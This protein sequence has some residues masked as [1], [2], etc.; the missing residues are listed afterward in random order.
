MTPD[1]PLASL[2]VTMRRT[3]LSMMVS[4]MGWLRKSAAETR[5]GQALD[6]EAG[7]REQAAG[8]GLFLR[9]A[10]HRAAHRGAIKD[11]EIGAAEHYAGQV[12]H[13]KLDHAVDPPVR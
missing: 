10:F 11:V 9:H 4:G 3:G 7:D 5:L 12:P 6:A 2:M 1:F 13:R 8:G